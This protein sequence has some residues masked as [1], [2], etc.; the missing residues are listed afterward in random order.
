VDFRESAIV[1]ESAVVREAAA[2]PKPPRRRARRGPN[3]FVLLATLAYLGIIG[4]IT[5]SP[6]DSGSDV[7]GLSY[8]VLSFLKSLPTGL[9]WDQL[10]F[11]LNIVMFVPLGVLLVLLFGPRFFWMAAVASLAVT[12]SIEGLQH[13][14][15][16]RV[17]DTRDLFANGLGGLLGMLAGLM[18]LGAARILRP[19]RT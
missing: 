4:F 7:Q 19:T 10:E 17:P 8:R 5:L 12:F 16:F 9:S 3:P 11:S 18:L 1:R 15:P 13:L 14:I 6:G 2:A